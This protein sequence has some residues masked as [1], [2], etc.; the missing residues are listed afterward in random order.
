MAFLLRKFPKR[1]PIS[2][3][4]SSLSSSLLRF[5]SSQTPP[6]SPSP[7]PNPLHLIGFHSVP[8]GDRHQCDPHGT[9]PV[10]RF[11]RL[12][13]QKDEGMSYPC[14]AQFVEN[15]N[16]EIGSTEDDGRKVWAD[17][18]KRKRKKKMNKHKYKKR[19]KMLAR[20]S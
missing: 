19:S 18:V 5:L 7:S 2:L 14:L 15:G 20:K 9:D 4:P 1:P 12:I 8:N 11:L 3:S 16:V 13:I 10:D 17:S 6:P